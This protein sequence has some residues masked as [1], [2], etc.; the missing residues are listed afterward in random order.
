M[1][2]ANVNGAD[3]DGAVGPDENICNSLNLLQCLIGLRQLL[4]TLDLDVRG[5]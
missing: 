3:E 2:V 4:L 1:H 5:G